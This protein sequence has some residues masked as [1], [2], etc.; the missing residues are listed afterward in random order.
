MASNFTAGPI[1]GNLELNKSFE[2]DMLNNIKSALIKINM[3]DSD[4]ISIAF[5]PDGST[6]SIGIASGTVYFYQVY[7]FSLLV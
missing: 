2:S 3:K 5:S 7:G 6:I 4:I 1:Y